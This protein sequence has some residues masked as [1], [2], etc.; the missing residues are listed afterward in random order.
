VVLPEQVDFNWKNFTRE[1]MKFIIKECREKVPVFG[2]TSQQCP[3]FALRMHISAGELIEQI[4]T[5]SEMTDVYR[6]NALERMSE[7]VKLR[8][9]IF[10]SFKSSN[11]TST[12]SKGNKQ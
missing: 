12:I 4:A 9:E 8:Y 2:H 11:E 3:A 5:N 1:I 7:T 10:Q 6:R